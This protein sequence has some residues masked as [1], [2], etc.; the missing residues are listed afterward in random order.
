MSMDEEKKERQRQIHLNGLIQGLGILSKKK[1][2][3][4]KQQREEGVQTRGI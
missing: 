4:R 1:V 2:V 3:C